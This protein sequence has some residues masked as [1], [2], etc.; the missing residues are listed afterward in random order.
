MKRILLASLAALVICHPAHADQ[1]GDK[2][3]ALMDAQG[4]VVTF[5]QQLS[6]GREYN[7]RQAREMQ[8]QMLNGLN[9]NE[10]FR[11]QLQLA[12]EEFTTAVQP[13]WGAQEI[14]NAWAQYY[15]ESFNDEELD[16]LLAHYT[17]PLAQKEVSASRQALARFSQHFQTLYSPIVEQATA[18][19]TKRLQTIVQECNCRK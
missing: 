1:R 11:T 4:L 17:S 6:A 9:L 10:Q 19:Y 5:E 2:I 8:D 13:P 16:R 14:V 18:A 7:Q 15:G 3:K 12:V